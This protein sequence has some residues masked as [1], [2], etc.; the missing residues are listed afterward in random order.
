MGANNPCWVKDV[1]KA[2]DSFV[3]KTHKKQIFEGIIM[4]VYADF[5]MYVRRI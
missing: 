5:N 4:G 3:V 1:K 2:N